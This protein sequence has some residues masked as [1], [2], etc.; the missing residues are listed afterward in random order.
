MISAL[1][2]PLC[3]APLACAQGGALLWRTPPFRLSARGAR[4]EGVL[5]DAADRALLEQLSAAAESKE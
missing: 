4:I 1:R 2:V 5:C 3:C